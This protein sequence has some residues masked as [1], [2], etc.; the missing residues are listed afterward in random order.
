MLSRRQ[1]HIWVMNLPVHKVRWPYLFTFLLASWSKV[2]LQRLTSPQLVKVPRILWNPKVHYR[3]HKCW[4]PVPIM[5]QLDPVHNPTFHSLK[6]H[7]NIILPFTPGSS[8][9]SLSLRFPHQSPVNTSPLPHKCYML[10][11]SRFDHL[12]HTGLAVQIIKLL[13]M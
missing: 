3:I 5:S 11:S 6:I 7:L 12:N 4:P 1:K 13:I 8:K 9:W 10:H 2:L